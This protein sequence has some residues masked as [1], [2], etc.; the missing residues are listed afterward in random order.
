MERIQGSYNWYL[1]HNKEIK[2]E[3]KNKVYMVN[4]LERESEN[5][6]LALPYPW[7]YS[8]SGNRPHSTNK[9]CRRMDYKYS[10][11]QIHFI[12]SNGHWDRFLKEEML[13]NDQNLCNIERKRNTSSVHRLYLTFLW[14]D[15]SHFVLFPDQIWNLFKISIPMIYK[16]VSSNILIFY[17]FLTLFIGWTSNL[18]IVQCFFNFIVPFYEWGSTASRMRTTMWR[19]FNFNL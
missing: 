13:N 10:P 9:C 5:C 12:K 3:N 14:L 7:G 4:H 8:I 11:F 16:K 6:N 1:G 17:P 2:C 19:Q 15:Q 18:A